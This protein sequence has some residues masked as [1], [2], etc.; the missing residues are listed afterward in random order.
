MTEER[1]LRAYLSSFNR[2]KDWVW[3][4]DELHICLELL[5]GDGGDYHWDN[6]TAPIK[7]VNGD[8]G[9]SAVFHQAWRGTSSIKY[10]SEGL[11]R[12]ILK[13]LIVPMIIWRNR[14]YLQ[15]FKDYRIHEGP[16]PAQGITN[17]SI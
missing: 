10:V 11:N 17:I 6:M 1:V 13:P 5:F 14:E 16:E 9:G 3:V 7:V 15:T 4:T 8:T 2:D 12:G